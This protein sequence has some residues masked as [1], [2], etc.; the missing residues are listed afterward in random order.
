M[1][2]HI[3]IYIGL[4]QNKIINLNYEIYQGY[5]SRTSL[6]EYTQEFINPI[7]DYYYIYLTLS[8]KIS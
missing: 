2:R 7:E 4:E 8:V 1:C 3:Y 6:Q 5:H